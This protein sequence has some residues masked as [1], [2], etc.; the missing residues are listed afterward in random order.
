M[1]ASRRVSGPGRTMQDVVLIDADA[2]GDSARAAGDAAD[3][4]GRAALR[5]ARRWWRLTAVLTLVVVVIASLVVDRR[6][7]ARLAA[8]EEVDGVLAPVNGPLEPRW[9]AADL[10]WLAPA[11]VDGR[12]VGLESRQDGSADVVAL[13]PA[14]GEPRW[15]TPAR[16]PGPIRGRVRCALPAGPAVVACVVVDEVVITAESTTGYSFAPTRARLLVADARTGEVVS[17]SPIAPS[18]SIAALR[19]DLVLARVD[20]AGRLRVERTDT[21]GQDRRWG[22]TSPEPLPVDDFRQRSVSVEVV[23]DLVFIG[24]GAAS[25][26]LAPDGELLDAWEPAP[27]IELGRRVEALPGALLAQPALTADDVSRT[28]VLD[29]LTGHSFTAVG[30]PIAPSLT[31]ESLAQLV[32][33]QSADRRELLAYDRTSGQR[34]WAAAGLADELLTI[35][36]RVL[37]AGDGQLQ[38][39]EGRT[40]KLLWTTPVDR[41]TEG[42][43]V[44]DGRVVVLTHHAF[45]VGVVL[46]AYSLSDGRPQWRVEVD[47]NLDLV[48]VAGRLYGWSVPGL[49][50][51]R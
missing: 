32:F 4:P 41:V 47:E 26:V 35:D 12:I 36:G 25:W 45:D 27:D 16:E 34:R 17:D 6:E 18:T 9:R 37:R 10:R 49:L 48:A 13:D 2:A 30:T 46:A 33:L 42:P 43:P 20:A 50:A 8:L 44:T 5:P 3:A 1:G 24:R 11:E 14:T 7:A 19:E 28:R 51:L 39:I 40:G 15:R 38:A 29:V 21:R 23:G 31:D 22:Y